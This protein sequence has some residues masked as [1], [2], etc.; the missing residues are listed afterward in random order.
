MFTT[1]LLSE[2]ESVLALAEVLDDA[3]ELGDD[4]HQARLRFTLIGDDERGRLARALA[5]C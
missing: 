2:Q 4:R 5:H 1:I 3:I